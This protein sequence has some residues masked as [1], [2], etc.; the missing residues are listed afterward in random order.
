MNY[1]SKHKKVSFAGHGLRPSFAF[2][3]HAFSDTDFDFVR[4]TTKMALFPYEMRQEGRSSAPVMKIHEKPSLM[5]GNY[6]HFRGK[7]GTISL[8]CVPQAS[9]L[10]FRAHVR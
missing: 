8:T 5:A 2:E 10:V 6:G 4:R 3:C 9:F 7:N 1:S